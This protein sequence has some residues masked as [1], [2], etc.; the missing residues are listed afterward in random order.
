[1]MAVRILF[2]VRFFFSW[3]SGFVFRIRFFV[4]AVR[5]HSHLLFHMPV[6]DNRNSRHSELFMCTMTNSTNRRISPIKV[7]IALAVMVSSGQVFASEIRIAAA[8]NF[9]AAITALARSFEASSG[10]KLA[11]AYGSTAKHY[12]Q[13]KQGAPY[14]VFFAADVSRPEILEK[15]GFALPGS[16]FTYAIGRIVL[17]SPHAGIV[18][19]AGKVLQQGD[20]RHLAIA[21]PELAPY[22]KAAQQVLQVIG[23]WDD[24]QSRI[25]RGENIGQTFQFISSGNAEMGFVARSQLLQPGKSIEGSFWEV[26]Q[27]HYD[28]IE[29]QAVLLK[30]NKVAAN[31]LLYVKSEQ[32]Q[33]IIRQYGYDV[34]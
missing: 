24:L 15:E 11:L 25:V 26:P 20:F 30:D 2:V 32:A 33:N 29:Q 3:L 8:S 19:P 22:G 31:F 23:L 17:W 1:M 27:S 7:L 4:V 5:I 21:N 18:D 28:A 6:C 34:P 10:S 14:D 9:R 16:R 13:I 12:A